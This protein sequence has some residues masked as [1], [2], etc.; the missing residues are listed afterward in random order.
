MNSVKE[1]EILSFHNSRRENVIGFDHETALKGNF[2]IVCNI[3]AL[4][5]VD[6]TFI[7]LVSN[8]GKYNDT[9]NHFLLSYFSERNLEMQIHLTCNRH[10]GNQLMV[11]RK[12]NQILTPSELTGFMVD[13]K[14]GT[15]TLDEAESWSIIMQYDIIHHEIY[16]YS[17]MRLQS[18]WQWAGFHH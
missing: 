8:E 1:W 13:F 4:D 15:P 17:L 10:W 6:G 5:F 12:D 11:I 3:T 9:A 16:Q 2:S 14:H 7:L 18:N